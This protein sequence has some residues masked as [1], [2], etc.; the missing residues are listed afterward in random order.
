MISWWLQYLA[1][2][3]MSDFNNDPGK[4]FNSS[5]SLAL[6][7]LFET[8]VNNEPSPSHSQLCIKWRIHLFRSPT[9][10]FLVDAI[11]VQGPHA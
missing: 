2:G 10:G 8:D 4:D 6:R 3:L 1:K 5:R 11:S 7:G 9:Y